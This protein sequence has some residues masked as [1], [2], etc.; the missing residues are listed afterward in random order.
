MET[1]IVVDISP[2][3][4]YLTKFWFSIYGPKCCQPVKLQDSLKCNIS[5]KKWMMKFVSGMQINIKV[6]YKLILSFWLCLTRHAQLTQN[7]KFAY[8]C[9]IF[10]K[11]WGMKLK[12]KKSHEIFCLRINTEV[13][14]KLIVLLWIC[15]VRHAQSTQSSKFTISL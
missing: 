11:A 2:P 13:F 1:N 7:K 4:P 5:R 8:L 6:F 12:L 9:N 3:I 14:Y 15:V 10:R